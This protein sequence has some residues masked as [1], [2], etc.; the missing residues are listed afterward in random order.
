MWFGED[1]QER[2]GDW[3]G[4]GCQ[5]QEDEEELPQ[6]EAFPGIT[7]ESKVFDIGCGNAA[8]LVYLAKEYNFKDL[9]GADYSEPGVELA[10]K[11]VAKHEE[12]QNNSTILLFDMTDLDSLYSRQNSGDL[13]EFKYDILYDKGTFDAI[14]LNANKAMRTRYIA[15]VVSLMKESSY[16]IITSCN[17]TH[18][19]LLQMFEP[20]S[21]FESRSQEH[22]QLAGLQP[23][24]ARL[25]FYKNLKHPEFSFGGRSGSTVATLAFKLTM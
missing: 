20:L 13:F 6:S 2:V 17:W 22:A 19:E 5:E 16:F 14:C 1:V 12:T 3:I 23:P 10:R 18:Q 11:V 4:L 7:R 25:Q 9:T 15:T 24:T 8:A 21:T